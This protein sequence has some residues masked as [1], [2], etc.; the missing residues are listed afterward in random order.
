MSFLADV[1]GPIIAAESA[2]AKDNGVKFVHNGDNEDNELPGVLIC[3]KSLQE[4]LS[5]L[6]NNAIKYSTIGPNGSVNEDPKVKLTLEPNDA[7][8]KVGVSIFIEDNGPGIPPLERENVFERGYRGSAVKNRISGDGIGLAV[9]RELISR[10]GGVV[11]I[12]DRGPGMLGGATFCITLFRNP[13]TSLK[14]PS[15][16]Q[17]T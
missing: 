17:I 10:M 16:A 2:I 11:E 13:N 7:L 12:L 3:P 5:N 14:Q 9:C 15:G 4:A 6:L 8:V 1:L